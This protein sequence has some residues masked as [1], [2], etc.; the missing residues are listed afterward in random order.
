MRR[1]LTSRTTVATASAAFQN[2]SSGSGKSMDAVNAELK[3]KFDTSLKRFYDN[4]GTALKTTKRSLKDEARTQF[5]GVARNILAVTPP[6]KSDYVRWGKDGKGS[7]RVDFASGRER[8]RNKILSNMAG[9]LRV[10]KS[11]SLVIKKERREP[12]SYYLSVRQE[13]RR[14]KKHPEKARVAVSRTQWNMIKKFLFERQGW[15]LSGWKALTGQFSIGLK[16]WIQRKNL[17][18]SCR[19]IDNDN[20]FGFEAVNGSH[21]V[22]DA[23]VQA[24]IRFGLDRQSK[25]MENAFKNRSERLI[26]QG[27]LA[28]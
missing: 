27:L 24:R 25:A 15:I 26:R 8:G 3:R 9:V 17:S 16:E 2:L 14:P 18:S 22:M 11:N 28:P 23:S 19:I 12:L 4:L 13:N 5:K 21:A 1:I 20:L 6:M 7:E 10:V